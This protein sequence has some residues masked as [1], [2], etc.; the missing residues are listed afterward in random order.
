MGKKRKVLSL[1][2]SLL[3]AVQVPVTAQ[4][5][6]VENEDL[7]I[8]EAAQEE[9]SADEGFISDEVL[10]EEDV[11]DENSVE[12]EQTEDSLISED[13]FEEDLVDE[14][15][16]EVTEDSDA[17]QEEA[18][19]VNE[20][21]PLEDNEP[22]LAVASSGQCGDNVYW[23]LSDDRVL[24]ISGSGDMWDWGDIIY[25]PWSGL[26]T[27][28]LEVV[29]E[30]GVTSI[31]DYAFEFCSSLTSVTIPDSVTSIGDS[32]F[33]ECLSLTSVTIPDSVTSIGSGTFADCSL[34]SVMIPDSVTSIGSGAFAGCGLLTSVTIPD[35]VTSIGD[36]AFQYC[37][38]S[39]VTIPD[40]VTSIGYGAFEVC[41]SLK[42]VIIGASVRTI[43]DGA[44]DTCKNLREVKF[45]GNAPTFE[46]YL[47]YD[48]YRTFENDTLI[49]YYPWQKS[50]W[51]ENVRQQYGGTITW[52]PTPA[53]IKLSSTS[54]TL[55]MG[56]STTIKVSGLVSGDK[57][58]SWK[59]SNTGVATVS[60]SGTITAKAAGTATVTVSLLSGLTATVKVTVKINKTAPVM[61][62]VYNSYKGGDINWKKVDGAVG[63]T[64]YRVR[65]AEGT[66]KVATINDV[67]TLQCYD[68]SIFFLFINYC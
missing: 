55:D 38:L 20:E 9:L 1:V 47:Y 13:I 33:C 6:A 43:G 31:G 26:K 54:V 11:S 36:S 17:F 44:F 30:P 34:L 64:V 40:S 52:V 68:S 42:S 53:T 45:T 56:K 58:T 57:V 67:N 35:S 61:K 8:E 62:A 7:I 15:L 65:S 27:V 28:I 46:K 59:S 25:A 41:R 3:M 24:T 21:S 22:A 23:T 51:T 48:A 39:S 10:L 66:R 32:A 12:E 18:D 60:S 19:P 14:T 49:A 16:E 63:Y 50:G 5:L 2:L 37:D 4:E 29:M